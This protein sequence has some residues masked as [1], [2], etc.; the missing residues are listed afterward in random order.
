M[1]RVASLHTDF[2]LA[3]TGLTFPPQP[4]D[5]PRSDREASPL[6]EQKRLTM[7]PTHAGTR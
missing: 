7:N 3:S 2:A 1:Q 4:F 5:C 6:P